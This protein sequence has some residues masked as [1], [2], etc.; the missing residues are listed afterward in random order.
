M[1]LDVTGEPFWRATGIAAILGLDGAHAS[2]VLS[3]RRP[4]DPQGAVVTTRGA[5]V[6]S[7]VSAALGVYPLTGLVAENAD[8]EAYARVLGVVLV[9]QVLGT[10]VAP[11]LR[12]L[13]G[14]AER[15]AGAVPEPA[16][17]LADEIVVTADRIEAQA[18][19]PQ[20]A[21]ECARLRRLA[22]TATRSA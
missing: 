5:V 7:A 12:R 9:A 21:A 22:A 11:L 13:G 2:F 6:A 8:S 10:A 14:G 15:A 20:V 1:W 17:R 19:Q 4:G 16:Q 18:P 3:R